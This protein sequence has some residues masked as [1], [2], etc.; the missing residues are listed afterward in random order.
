[1]IDK[2][3]HEF[4]LRDWEAEILGLG[5]EVYSKDN[6]PPREKIEDIIKKSMN[7]AGIEGDVLIEENANKIFTAFSTLFRTRSKTVINTIESTE[8]EEIDTNDMRDETRGISSFR[9]D[10][11]LFYTNKYLDEI[12]NDEQKSI[13]DKFLADYSLPRSACNQINFY[14]F[15]TPLNMVIA[16]KDPEYKFIKDYLTDNI[17]ARKIDSWIKSRDMGFYSIEYSYKINSHTKISTFNPDF[18]IKLKTNGNKYVFIEIKD[19]KDVSPENKG[20]NRASKE[21]FKLLNAQ[22][23]AEKID[24]K[25]LFHFLSPIDYETFFQYL[26]E[27][28]LDNFVSELDNLLED[29]DN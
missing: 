7:N 21:H 8:F 5:D 17:N 15:K 23:Q 29:L 22:L 2:I 12:Q 16:T 25:Y 28:K 24:E 13:M 3:Y 10:S 19:D 18:I 27:D 20:K 11:M 9:T 4:M 6:L 1:M 26:R 14:D